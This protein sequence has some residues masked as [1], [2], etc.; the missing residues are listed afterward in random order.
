M[1]NKKKIELLENEL[2]QL[3][4]EFDKLKNATENIANF[5][6]VYN[7]IIVSY[8]NSRDLINEQMMQY[9]KKIMENSAVVD[10]RLLQFSNKIDIAV[11]NMK[12]DLV[13]FVQNQTNKIDENILLQSN[14]LNDKGNAILQSY[15]SMLEQFSSTHAD[16]ISDMLSKYEINLS[17]MINNAVHRELNSLLVDRLAVE[18][19]ERI[20]TAFN[21]SLVELGQ[22][23]KR[24]IVDAIRGLL[25]DK[26]PVS[27][28][29]SN[30]I[31]VEKIRAGEVFH[32]SYDKLKMCIK[33]GVVPMLVGPAGTGK[34]SAVEQLSRDLGLSFYMANRIQNTFE[35]V[36]FVNAAGSYVTT[37]FYEAYSKGGLFLF[38]EIDASSPE[39]LVTINTAISQGF[40]A[41]PGH[42]QNIKM[43]PDFKVVCA[44]NTYGTGA[45]LQYTGRNKLDAATLDRFMIINWDYDDALESAL[46]KDKDLLELCW[47]FREV[48]PLVDRTIIISTRGIISLEKMINQNK[49]N[50]TYE[51]GELIKSKFF[52][53]MSSDKLNK[54]ISSCADLNPKNKYIKDLK[55][56]VAND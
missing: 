11:D 20:L 9:D 4:S 30:V 45:T 10:E 42:P 56:M 26:L 7:K 34:S 13:E 53:N 8:N 3:V 37:Q 55:A 1:F 38:D 32:K 22:E 47:K 35:L 17:E 54:I 50:K 44:G 16:Q 24:K 2:K 18:G 5:D 6:D 29:V 41:F 31:E 52:E 28:I 40:M 51:V 36:G 15:N 48:A 12:V 23:E 25:V 49:E 43:H 46:I 14:I 33:A 19:T 27:N 21:K 39:A